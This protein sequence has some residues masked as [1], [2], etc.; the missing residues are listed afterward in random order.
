MKERNVP[1]QVLRKPKEWY[2]WVECF[3]C[4]ETGHIRRVCPLRH[5][6]CTFCG[7]KGHTGPET[8]VGDVRMNASV[9][10]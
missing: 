2:K 5:S 3:C 4:G 6:R 1:S 8:L 10:V 9:V 7:A